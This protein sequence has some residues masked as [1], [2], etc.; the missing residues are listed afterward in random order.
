MF[1]MFFPCELTRKRPE[2]H[3]SS[4][5]SASSRPPWPWSAWPAHCAV[6]WGRGSPARAPGLEAG[7]G[8]TWRVAFSCV[9][10]GF[11]RISMDFYG[12]LV[13]FSLFG[14]LLRCFSSNSTAQNGLGASPAVPPR[15][16]QSA[17]SPPGAVGGPAS[18]APYGWR[19]C[20]AAPVAPGPGPRLDP[21]T[22]RRKQRSWAQKQDVTSHGQRGTCNSAIATFCGPQ[23]RTRWAPRALARRRPR[24]HG[25]G[26]RLLRGTGAKCLKPCWSRSIAAKRSSPKAPSSPTS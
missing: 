25:N 12:F 14:R 16:A 20:H 18:E 15:S 11:P 13:D 8:A 10:H 26:C 2:T 24:Q 6:P 17:P 1:I 7:A 21:P 22:A 4:V 3:A 19:R 23:R 9:F 5:I